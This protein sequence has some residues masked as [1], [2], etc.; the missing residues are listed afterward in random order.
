MLL[1]ASN[2]TCI[3]LAP[4]MQDSSEVWKPPRQNLDFRLRRRE[5][6]LVHVCACKH[7]T[8]KVAVWP[9]ALRMRTQSSTWKA[10]S[11]QT[12]VMPLNHFQSHSPPSTGSQRKKAFQFYKCFAFVSVFL[13][14][15]I[16]RRVAC[17]ISPS[18]QTDFLQDSPRTVVH[19]II[20]GDL[21][22]FTPPKSTPLTIAVKIMP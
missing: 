5:K 15:A 12:A 1:S 18:N 10:T 20:T 9:L 16:K 2:P 11:I 21:V 8:T 17:V 6:H 14:N 4:A 13:T 22:R 7:H 19:G 3:I